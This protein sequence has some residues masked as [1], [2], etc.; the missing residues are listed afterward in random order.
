M[1]YKFINGQQNKYMG[2]IAKYIQVNNER[3]KM[4]EIRLKCK[5]DLFYEKTFSYSG[6]NFDYGG[7]HLRQ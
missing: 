3:T 4:K 6:D 7:P 5:F 1:S 2:W